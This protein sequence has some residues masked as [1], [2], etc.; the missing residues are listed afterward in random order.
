MTTYQILGFCSL[1]SV[2]KSK[3]IFRYRQN[4]NAITALERKK[5][6]RNITKELESFKKTIYSVIFSFFCSTG[7]KF[8][9]TFG[10]PI[11]VPN[12]IQ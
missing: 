12:L 1:E 7:H 2:E 4:Q 5:R 3:G 9:P 6:A 8:E 11:I 10:I